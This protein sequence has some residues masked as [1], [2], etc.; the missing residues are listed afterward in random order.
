MLAIYGS[1]LE[2][3]SDEYAFISRLS[4]YERP[5]FKNQ[6]Y[7]EQDFSSFFIIASKLSET[8]QPGIIA[9]LGWGQVNGYLQASNSKSQ[10]Y[11]DKQSYMLDGPSTELEV[12]YQT[13]RVNLALSYKTCLGIRDQ[14]QFDIKVLWPFNYITLKIGAN[15]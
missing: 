7:E 11:Y 15:I 2:I 14:E 6:G 5:V 13:S 9:G 3:A 1:T 12:L 10:G 4:Y 8:M